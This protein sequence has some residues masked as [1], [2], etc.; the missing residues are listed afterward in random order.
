MQQLREPHQFGLSNSIDDKER[1]IL[2]PEEPDIEVIPD[3][4]RKKLVEFGE[5]LAEMNEIVN[6]M[7]G[8]RRGVVVRAFEA[9]VKKI[10]HDRLK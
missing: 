1:R 7:R 6:T 5:G 3:D 8:V 4:E 2:F 10:E 9:K